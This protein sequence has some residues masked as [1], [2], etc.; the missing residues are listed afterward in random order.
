M[1]KEIEI[2]KKVK[3]VK[4]NNPKVGDKVWSLCGKN[5]GLSFEH[6]L[7]E[8]LNE[9]LFKTSRVSVQSKDNIWYEVNPPVFD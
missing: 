1:I 8:E 3:L 2:T 6:I 5:N 7:I 4:A 9:M